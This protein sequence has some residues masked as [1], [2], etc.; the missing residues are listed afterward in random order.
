MLSFVSGVFISVDDLP[1]WLESV[2]KVFPLYHLADGLQTCLASGVGGTGLDGGNVTALALWGLV[3][4][5]TA[6]RRFHWEPQAAP[7]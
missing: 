1:N 5:F 2:G 7:A 6:V 4:A 3:G